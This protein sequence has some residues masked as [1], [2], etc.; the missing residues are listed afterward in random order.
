VVHDLPLRPDLLIRVVLPVHFTADD[1]ER[2][3]GMLRA[4][5]FAPQATHPKETDPVL[6][7]FGQPVGHGKLL[8]ATDPKDQP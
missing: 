3:C 8:A 2:L 6:P 1:A 7:T 5:A 4:L